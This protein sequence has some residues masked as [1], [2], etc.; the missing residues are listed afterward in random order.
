M[1]ANSLLHDSHSAIFDLISIGDEFDSDQY[2]ADFA[3]DTLLPSVPSR[4]PSQAVP[5]T[6]AV[7]ALTYMDGLIQSHTRFYVGLVEELKRQEE[8]CRMQEA[9]IEFQKKKIHTLELK[10]ADLADQLMAKN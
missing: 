4:Q 3:E 10:A 1:S 8:K 6:R 5:K 7:G 2:R 9:I